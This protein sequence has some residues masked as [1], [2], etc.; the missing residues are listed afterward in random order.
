VTDAITDVQ[1]LAPTVR[2]Y[3]RR[4]VP[5]DYAQYARMRKKLAG[6]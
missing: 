2:D 6:N 4:R 5:I 1:A 3:V